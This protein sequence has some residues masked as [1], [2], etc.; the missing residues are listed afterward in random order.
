METSSTRKEPDGRQLVSRLGCFSTCF[1]NIRQ[2]CQ[3]IG[4]LCFDRLLHRLR[5]GQSC[6]SRFFLRDCVQQPVVGF[7]NFKYDFSV[8]VVKSEIGREQVGPCLI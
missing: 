2:S 4:E 1:E 6:L 5:I 8:R 3:T 7:G